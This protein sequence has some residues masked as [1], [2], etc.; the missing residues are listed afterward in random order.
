MTL[1]MISSKD[2][3]F[4]TW[5]SASALH[6]GAKTSS[7]HM[8][9]LCVVSLDATDIVATTRLKYDKGDIKPGCN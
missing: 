1:L 4:S 5:L 8:G 6:K 2:F 9:I 7:S 3:M